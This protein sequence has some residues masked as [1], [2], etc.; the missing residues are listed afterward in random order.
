[1]GMIGRVSDNLRHTASQQTVR[2]DTA[3]TDS[4]SVRFFQ[5]VAPA[6]LSAA[7]EEGDEPKINAFVNK[8]KGETGNLG[9]IKQRADKAIHEL[10]LGNSTLAQNV[11][12]S[13]AI[14]SPKK[15][16]APDAFVPASEKVKGATPFISSFTLDTLYDGEIITDLYEQRKAY[17][18]AEEHQIHISKLAEYAE[19]AKSQILSTHYA[20]YSNERK[21]EMTYIIPLL[22]AVGSQNTAKVKER[23]SQV[24]TFGRTASKEDDLSVERRQAALA[25]NHLLNVAEELIKRIEKRDELSVS[26]ALPPITIGRVGADP[27]ISIHNQAMAARQTKEDQIAY[28]RDA[29][30]LKYEYLRESVNQLETLYPTLKDE[31]NKRRAMTM[32]NFSRAS[33]DDNNDVYYRLVDAM[34]KLTVSPQSDALSVVNAQAIAGAC[35]SVA[36]FHSVSKANFV[37]AGIPIHQLGT[38]KDEGRAIADKDKTESLRSMSD[39]YSAFDKPNKASLIYMDLDNVLMSEKERTAQDDMARRLNE[40]KAG[41]G[42]GAAELLIHGKQT[43]LLFDTLEQGNEHASTSSKTQREMS[44]ASQFFLSKAKGISSLSFI[45]SAFKLVQR[46]SPKSEEK[47]L[48]VD[49]IQVHQE[50]SQ[51]KSSLAAGPISTFKNMVCQWRERDEKKRSS[52]SMSYK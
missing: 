9:E 47:Q 36:G 37:S 8:A 48:A 21:D 38:R 35:D 43:A 13:E 5:I 32:M 40:L 50:H 34:R 18:L 4:L 52:H 39:Y 7:G 16:A 51:A 20:Y 11:Q 28:S 46:D 41:A 17:L 14:T 15:E 33:M 1:M 25:N 26:H 24:R 2:M 29:I 19:K 30:E 22:E 44:N 12:S 42:T 3:A 27:N 10:G 45:Q 6:I 23:I 49:A 31:E